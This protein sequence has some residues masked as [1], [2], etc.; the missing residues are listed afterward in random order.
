MDR[1][2]ENLCV[3]CAP[4]DVDHPKVGAIQATKMRRIISEAEDRRGMAA[5]AVFSNIKK[6]AGTIGADL[7]RQ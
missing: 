6:R 3:L 4:I 5:A 2:I 1:K 7:E